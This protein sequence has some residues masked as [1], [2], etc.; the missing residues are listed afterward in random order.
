MP[1]EAPTPQ[2]EVAKEIGRVVVDK[3]AQERRDLRVERSQNRTV[4]NVNAQATPDARLRALAEGNNIQGGKE[5]Q[6]T[7]AAALEWVKKAYKEP[8][9]SKFSLFFE[10]GEEYSGD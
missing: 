9:M 1:A 7:K 10:K 8:T 3:D 4:E 5:W 2:A 6:D